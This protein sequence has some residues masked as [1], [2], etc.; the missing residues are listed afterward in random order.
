[1]AQREVKKVM[2]FKFYDEQLHSNLKMQSLKEQITLQDLV[3]KAC[4]E[5]LQNVKLR[6]KQ[7]S[8]G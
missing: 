8:L 3:T 4:K 1:M 6:K 7:K 5:Y 2:T